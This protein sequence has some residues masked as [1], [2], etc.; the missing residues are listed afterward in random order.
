MNRGDHRVPKRNSP[1]LTSRKKDNAGMSRD[2][3]MPTVTRTESRAAA[4][5]TIMTAR[6]P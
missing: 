6:S 4:I 5:S 2:T 3:T 1:T